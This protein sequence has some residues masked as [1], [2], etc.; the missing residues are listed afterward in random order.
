MNVISTLND[1]LLKQPFTEARNEAQLLAYY[2]RIALSYAEIENSLAVLSDLKCDKS[3]VYYG[4]TAHHLGIAARGAATEID[5][6]WEEEI[7][8]RIHP[9][10]L[11]EKH[12]LELQFFHLL[13]SLP[14]DQRADYHI[15]SPMRMRNQE[16]EY[17]T[18]Q[19][20]MFYV[21]NCPE[22]NF[23][24]ALCL[25]GH[26]PYQAPKPDSSSGTIINSATGKVIRPDNIR[27]NNILSAREKEIVLL[28]EKGKLSKEI[29]AL[30]SIS[31][32]T[33]NRHRQN[34]LEKLR[35]KNSLEA[36][37]MAR[38]MNLL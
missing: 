11:T 37:R 27:C 22:G 26:Y 33:V 28:I 29:A 18:I 1:K 3:Y 16:G 35:V 21:C 36:C 20:R 10:D 8:G 6:I 34:V 17:E 15:V 30:L 19:H 38:L 24:L 2:Q 32:N 23:W 12:M 9:D 7:F 31:I 25:Y 14:T 13:K 4:G 5:S